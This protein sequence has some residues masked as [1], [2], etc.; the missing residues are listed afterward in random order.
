M[1]R[2]PLVLVTLLTF[3][4]TGP[5]DPAGGPMAP[6]DAPVQTDSTVYHLRH[7]D[8]EYDA[9]AA[10]TYTNRTGAPVYFARCSGAATGPLFYLR[11]TGADSA[12]SSFIGEGWACVGGVPTGMVLPGASLSTRVWLGSTDSPNAQP[13]IR[14]DERVGSFRVE[15]LLCARA[16]TDSDNC[17]PVPPPARQSNAF[18]VRF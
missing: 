3:A 14:S 7:V 17:R 9:W 18:E 15:F 13:P 2:T 12:R 10:A 8:G 4:C 16:E 11:R 6:D 5:D 1:R